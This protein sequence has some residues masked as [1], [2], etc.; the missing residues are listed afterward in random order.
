MQTPAQVNIS[1]VIDNSRLGP[2]QLAICI[3]C[4]LFLI[5]DGFDVQAMGYV[6]PAIIREWKIPNAELGPVFGAG[7]LGVLIGSLLFSMLA[8]KIGRRPVLIGAT[9]FFSAM[10][11]VTAHAN[12][13]PQLLAIRFIAGM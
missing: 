4:G 2:F 6:A 12:S 11:F 3:L 8:D 10:T 1:E 7:L 5:M 13:V 9:L